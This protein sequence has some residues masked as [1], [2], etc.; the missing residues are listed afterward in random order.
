MIVKN[1]SHIIKETLTN[2]TSKIK[3]NYYVICDTGSDDGTPEIIKIFFKELGI[4]GE[5]YYDSWKDFGTNRSLALEKAYKKADYILIFDADDSI[6]GDIN[7]T[8]LTADAYMINMGDSYNKYSRMCLVSGNIKWKY[9]GVLHEY[10]TTVEPNLEIKSESILGDYYIISGRTS[11]RNKDPEKY[12]KDARIL[13]QA[14]YKA[15][16]ENDQISNRYVYYTANSYKDAGNTDES[17]KWYLLTLKAQGWYDE[18][19][20]SCLELYSLYSSKQLTHIGCYYLVKSWNYNNKRVEG[21]YLLVQHYTCESEYQIAYNYYT[22]VQNYYEN[23]FKPEILNTFLFARAMDYTFYLPY[24]LII[25]CEKLKNYS[26]GIKMYLIIFETKVNPGQWWITN[27]VYNFQFYLS[28]LPDEIKQIFLEKMNKYFEFLKINGIKLDEKLINKYFNEL[29]NGN[30]SNNGNILIYT[31][32]SKDLWNLSYSETHALGGSERA[33]INLAKEL[34]KDYSIIISGD[35]LEETVNINGNFIKFLHRFKL[36]NSEHSEYSLSGQGHE[37]SLSGQGHEYSIIIVSRYVSF[38]TIYPKFK[39]QKLILMAH[40]TYFM[41]NL[42]GCP[43]THEELVDNNINSVDYCVCLTEWHK[44]EYSRIYPKLKNKIKVIN[45]GIDLISNKNFFKSTDTFVYTSGSIRGLER[46]LELWPEILDNIPDAKL[47]ISSYED[48]PKDS[49]DLKLQKIINEYPSI[50]HYG[51]LNKKQLYKLM[52]LSEYWLYPCCFDETSC[53]TAMEMMAHE[54]ICLYYPRAGLTDTMNGN[55]IQVSRGNEISTILNLTKLDKVELISKAKEYSK[56]CSWANRALEWNKLLN[57]TDSVTE[58]T[59]KDLNYLL[60]KKIILYARPHFA[61]ELLREYVDSLNTKIKVEYT[62]SFDFIKENNF[63]EVIF[64]HEVFDDRVFELK[65][66]TVSY[67]NTEPLNLWARLSYILYDVHGTIGNKITY[68]Y[69]YSLSNIKIM[70]KHGIKNTFHLPYL[71]NSEEVRSL[72]ELKNTS[73]VKYDFGIICS[74]SIW[75]TEINNLTPPRRKKVVEYLIS[76]GFKVNIITGFNLS[77]DCELAKCK[78]ILNIHGQYLE[79]PSKIFEHIR[80]NRLLYAGYSILSE[81]SDSLASEFTKMFPNLE[82]IDYNSFFKIKKNYCFIHSCNLPTKGI[83]R[84]DYLIN[85]LINSRLNLIFEKI[86]INN[87]GE[88][89][90]NVWNLPNVDITNYSSECNLFEIP[91]INKIKQFSEININVNILY[92]HT[93]GISFDDDYLE[94]NDWIDMM[95][96]FLLNKNCINLLNDYDTLGCNYITSGL[97][98]HPD[99]TT[100][101]APPHYSGNFWWAKSEY[102]RTL[103]LIPEVGVTINKNDAEYWLMKL[104]PNYLELHHSGVDHYRERYPKELIIN[105]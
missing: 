11:S 78:R 20:C 6:V 26:V 55:G 66:I 5:I 103:P 43:K 32:F 65:N 45:N 7:L 51:K 31:G 105:T 21:I 81:T 90:E 101:T 97:D 18:R 53:I 58:L 48:F 77:R 85:E 46:L 34:S 50:K 86:F 41:N 93:K 104:N 68:F 27:L 63:D 30:N 72:K 69:D 62:N 79:E 94:E 19:Y 22:L 13:E 2:L 52:E 73:E 10:I 70:N 96:H 67:L 1:E 17:I 25:V 23:E 100:T 71:Y 60:N 54:V 16:E 84:L 35:V 40:D 95:L 64:V 29:N 87:I 42:T 8:N 36:V 12:I 56:E 98:Y 80:C 61:T 92:I 59:K 4:V 76:Q 24:Y 49:F 57:E 44:N 15:I 38:F 89:I 47:N 75:T 39:C 82:L 33:V 88:P 3:F 37:Y 91:T 9:V 99:G 83:K 28:H 102:L 14:Y 74:S